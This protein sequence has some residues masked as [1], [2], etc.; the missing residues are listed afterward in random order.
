MSKFSIT[1]NQVHIW[2]LRPDDPRNGREDFINILSGSERE[3]ANRL[4]FESDRST[5]IM[6][7]GHLRKLLG[8]YLDKEPK[9]LEID[10]GKYGKP[11]LRKESNPQNINFNLSH[12][13]GASIYAIT[14][15]R[16]IGIDI[17]LLRRVTKADK[18][19]ER[20]Y[21]DEEKAYY[22]NSLRG[23]NLEAFFTLWCRREAYSKA[24][25]R[26]LNLPQG[27][28]DISFVT[29]ETKGRKDS[30]KYS[31]I[32]LYDLTFESGF[33]SCLAV[34]GSSPEISYHDIEQGE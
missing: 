7:R 26:G 34:S 12:T 21:S 15:G 20:F 28:I 5:F 11:Y 3:R 14:K 18:I 17:E 4:R 9:E 30:V 1:D 27:E 10:Y 24:L 19:I 13:K 22:R 8:S 6:T 33:F 16:E 25:G 2:R 32:G 23:E 29:K 31:A